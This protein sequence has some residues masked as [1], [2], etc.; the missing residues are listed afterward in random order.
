MDPEQ[1]KTLHFLPDPTPGDDDH[2]K[3]F[4]DVYGSATT[5]EHCHSLRSTRL[6]SLSFTP[7]Q[8]HAKNV[9]VLLQCDE[10]Y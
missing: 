3:K 7:S 2:Y 4:V 5:E 9:G 1:F 8:Q 10:C 6:Q